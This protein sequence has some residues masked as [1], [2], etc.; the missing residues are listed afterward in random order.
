MK[1]KFRNKKSD[2]QDCKTNATV[3]STFVVNSH[4]ERRNTNV[5]NENKT[6]DGALIPNTN[7][8]KGKT[9]A[10]VKARLTD[11]SIQTPTPTRQYQPQTRERVQRGVRGQVQAPRGGGKRPQTDNVAY[12]KN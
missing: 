6:R 5:R 1:Q 9:K 10:S 12:E 7:T 3:R 8:R 4:D 11:T 2:A